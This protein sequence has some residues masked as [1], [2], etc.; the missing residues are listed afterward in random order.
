M[1]TKDEYEA[2]RARV[3]SGHGNERDNQLVEWGAKQAGSWGNSM[4][5]AQK[6]AAKHEKNRSSSWF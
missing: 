1:A 3:A 4:R 2:A 5:E 6:S